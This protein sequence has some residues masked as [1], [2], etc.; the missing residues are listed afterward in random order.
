MP[1]SARTDRVPERHR[2]PV[3][4]HDRLVDPEH[5]GR[6]HG[7]RR[8]RLVHLEQSRSEAELPAFL[9]AFRGRGRGPCAARR[10]GRRTCRR[11]RS[12]RSGRDRVARR[13]PRWRPRPRAAPSL[14]CDAFPAVT[15]PASVNA[16]ASA[17]SSRF[18]RAGPDPL[19]ASTRDRVTLPLRDL[20]RLHLL[21]EEPGVPSVGGAHMRSRGPRVLGAPRDVELARSIASVPSPMC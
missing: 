19:I 6:V 5:P 10:S 8:E 17:S 20:D 11:R 18:G 1:G 16:G 9:G 21:G 2:A 7:H 4:V 14:I 12:R 13:P 3:H 15:V